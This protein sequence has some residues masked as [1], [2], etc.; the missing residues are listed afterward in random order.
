MGPREVCC[1]RCCQKASDFIPPSVSAF[2]FALFACVPLPLWPISLFFRLS[3]RNNDP[4]VWGQTLCCF[5]TA[6]VGRAAV[7]IIEKEL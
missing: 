7:C 4:R 5:A 3:Q 2:L 1:P 6:P